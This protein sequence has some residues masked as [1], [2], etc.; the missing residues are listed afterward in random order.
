[1][2]CTNKVKQLA[3]SCQN[4][5]DARQ[6]FPTLGDMV[7][8]KFKYQAGASA[9]F[10]LMPFIELQQAYEGAI[11]DSN[12]T[13]NC[14]HDTNTMKAIDIFSAALCPSNSVTTTPTKGWQPNNYV[15][16]LGDG[17]WTQR[18]V[19]AKEEDYKVCHRGMFYYG[20]NDIFGKTFAN[21]QDGTS[22]TVGISECLTPAVPYST[23]VKSN[24]AMF[25]GIWD[26]TYYGKP[27]N[28]C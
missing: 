26:G 7:Q 5:H 16:S 14:P 9:F 2:A 19:L 28:F 10:Q 6:R 21:C 18:Y 25:K 3:L 15:F 4:F 27:H 1:M 23:N 12:G 22:N 13:I 20:T 24:I 11:A 17:C 8:G